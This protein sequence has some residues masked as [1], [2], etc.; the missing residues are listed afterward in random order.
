[1]C[2]IVLRRPLLAIITKYGLKLENEFCG[3]NHCWGVYEQNS[4]VNWVRVDDWTAELAIIASNGGV[5][6][7]KCASGKF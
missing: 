6:L 4:I 3:I 5:M 2:H 7:L 1:M